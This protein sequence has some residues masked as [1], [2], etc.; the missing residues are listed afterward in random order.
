MRHGVLF[1]VL[2]KEVASIHFSSGAALPSAK[3]PADGGI[4]ERSEA[5]RLSK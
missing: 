1:F 3:I 4:E 5:W 2:E